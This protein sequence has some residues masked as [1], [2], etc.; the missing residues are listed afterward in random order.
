MQ[1]LV[2]VVIQTAQGPSQSTDVLNVGSATINGA[3][4]E[5]TFI[6]VPWL[7]INGFFSQVQ[8]KYNQFII[9]AAFSPKQDGLPFDA[10]NAA[11]FA[12]FPRTSFG[13]TA[14]ATLPWVPEH[15]G[16]AILQLNYYPPE[17]LHTAG[18][19]RFAAIR[20]RARLRRCQPARGMGP[21][22]RQ[23]VRYRGIR[24]QSR[25]QPLFGGHLHAGFAKLPRVR[26]FGRRAATHV[27]LRSHLPF[28]PVT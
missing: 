20:K 24:D 6:P 18:L 14:R 28:R 12:G 16:D 3:E 25:R 27:R 5:V 9:P 15:Y 2:P 4:L 8:P 22:A 19:C 17:R 13:L 21:R 26:V 7:N 10:T 1:R 23:Q 11:V